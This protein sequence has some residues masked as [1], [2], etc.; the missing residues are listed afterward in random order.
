MDTMRPPVNPTFRLA[1]RTLQG[2]LLTLAAVA[3]A[4]A[5]ADDLDLAQAPLFLGT[6]VDANVFFQVD[7]SGSMDWETLV[8]EFDYYFNYWG[9]NDRDK[10]NH[11]RWES[12]ASTGGSFTGQR[13]YGY[14]FAESDRL[15]KTTGEWGANAEQNPEAVQRD[16]RVR[17]SS[18]NLVYYDPAQTYTPWPGMSNASFTAARSNPQSGSDGYS[19][20]R[21]LTGFVFEVWRDDHGYDGER[22]DGPGDANDTPNGIVDLW[23]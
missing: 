15:Y 12:Y 14:M 1:L 6:S 23:D 5:R 19:S 4:C 10:I 3:W 11:G 13:S 7:D 2:W 21:N 20:Q 9:D 22:P 16:W 8:S 17:S 18:F